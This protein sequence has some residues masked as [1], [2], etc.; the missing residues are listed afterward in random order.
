MPIDLSQAI[1]LHVHTAPDVY[2]RSVDDEGAALQARARGLKAIVLKSH[3]TLTADRAALCQQR[4]PGIGVYGGLVLN[5]TVGGLNPVAVETALA[6]GAKQIWMP[7]MHSHRCL[8]DADMEQFRAEARKGRR[9]ITILDGEGRLD[10]AVVPTLEAILEMVRDAGAILGSG[11]LAPEE[12]LELFTLARHIGVERL[13][14][15]HPLMS[16]IGFSHSQLHH[17]IALGAKLE[18]DY[19]SCC[20]GWHRAIDPAVTAEA[21]QQIGHRHCIL[22]SDGGQ[23]WNPPPVD[24][25]ATFAERMNENGIAAEQLRVMLCDNPSELLDI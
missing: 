11:H 19:L 23:D 7:T 1:D 3:H 25:L 24:M 5:H 6:F 10:A 4:V 14:V 15:T 16:F 13:L 18:F 8:H 12:T 2:A 20:P 21:I 22:A 9:G 17:V